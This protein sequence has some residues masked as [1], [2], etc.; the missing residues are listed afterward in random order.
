MSLI[1]LPES[2]EIETSR[3]CNRLCDWCP[4]STTKSRINQEL[5][6]WHL[7]I[8]ILAELKTLQY[9]GKVALHNYNEP[10]ANPRILEELKALREFLPNSFQKIFTN[11]DYLNGQTINNLREVGLNLIKVSLYPNKAYDES[12]AKDKS[13][14]IILNWLIQKGINKS[15]QWTIVETWQGF[16]AISVQGGLTIEVINRTTKEFNYRGG[17]ISDI[18]R[19]HRTVPCYATQ[20]MAAI[21]YQGLLKMCLN[22]YPEYESHKKYIIGDLKV[23]SF[24]DLWISNIMLQYRSFHAKGQWVLSPLCSGCSFHAWQHRAKID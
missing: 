13:I 8:K 1:L 2:I 7:F 6:P 19:Q 17:T 16:A 23:S 18:Y 9:E 22:I 14:E 5:M 24:I 15:F 10:L 21:S 20:K 4:N 12:C 11:G 3:Y